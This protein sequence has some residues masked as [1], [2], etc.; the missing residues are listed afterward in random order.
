MYDLSI[1]IW[2]WVVTD[3]WIGHWMDRDLEADLMSVLESCLR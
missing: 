3:P 2:V 1:R